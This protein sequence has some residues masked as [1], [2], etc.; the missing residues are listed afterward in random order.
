[1]PKIVTVAAYKGG[2]GKTTLALELAYLLD[3]PLVDL[4]WDSGGA[5][6]RWGYRPTERSP[7]LD[8]LEKDKAPRPRKGRGKPDLVPGDRDFE[9]NQPEPEQMAAT[10][11]KWA[12]EWDRPYV[13]VDS[14][15]GG[16]RA[17]LGAM[18]AASV[19]VTPAVLATAEMDGLEGMIEEAADYPLLVIPN[20]VPRV[21]KARHVDR[22]REL[23]QRYQVPVGPIVSQHVRLSDR[24]ARIALTAMEPTPK[25]WQRYVEQLHAVA[26]AIRNYE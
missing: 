25:A 4:D 8:A 5:T 2:V 1:M 22:L 20:K 12:V 26:D 9:V 3:A 24:S 19:V 17:T 23:T 6:R 14:H 7:L 16:G 21:P 11:E 15:P 18:N 10:L 13:M